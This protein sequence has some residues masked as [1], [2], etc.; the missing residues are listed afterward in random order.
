VLRNKIQEI[1]D[2]KASYFESA[3]R[4]ADAQGLIAAPDAEAKAKT[5]LMFIQGALTQAR[6]Q[7]NLEVLRDIYPR[8]LELLGA[9]KLQPR[10]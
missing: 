8:A 4:H 6:I 3:I 5:L 7:N 1:L 10:S 9:T 2:R